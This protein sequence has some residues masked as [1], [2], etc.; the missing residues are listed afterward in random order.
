MRNAARARSAPRIDQ[1][2]ALACL[3]L[4]S[5]GDLTTVCVHHGRLGYTLT[6]RRPTSTTRCPAT[7]APRTYAHTLTRSHGI[8]CAFAWQSGISYRSNVDRV[9]AE[10]KAVVGLDRRCL[11]VFGAEY[12]VDEVVIAS[13]EGRVEVDLGSDAPRMV[14]GPDEAW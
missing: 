11:Q 3:L 14:C 9:S 1:R 13:D 4:S 5:D 7:P 10:V 6:S 8:Q 12:R 2:T